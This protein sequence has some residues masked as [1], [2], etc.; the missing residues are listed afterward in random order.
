MQV[1]KRDGRLEAVDISKITKALERF[2]RADMHD[3]DIARVARL[4]M[5]NL[6]DGATTRQIDEWSVKIAAS[7]GAE[8]PRYLTFAAHLFNNVINK[9]VETQGFLDFEKYW[10]HLGA[11]GYIQPQWIDPEFQDKNRMLYA[12]INN[13]LLSYWDEGEGDILDSF[14]GL[15]ALYSSYLLRAKV[16]NKVIETVPHLMMRVALQLVP[17]AAHHAGYY[18]REDYQRVHELF[19]ALMKGE[20]MPGTPTLFNSCL[21]RNQLASC[22]LLPPPDDSIQGI[23]DYMGS[24]AQL[25][26]WSGG[27][28]VPFSSVRGAGSHIFGT[29]GKSQGIIPFLKVLDSTV[30]AVNQ[31]GKRKGACAVYL[32]PW[33]PDIEEFLELRD[34]TGAESRRTHNLN[35]VNWVP[36]LFM[37]AVENDDYWYLIDPT[38]CDKGQLCDVYGQKFE[39]LYMNYVSRERYCKRIK[40]RDLYAKMMKTLAETGNG[41]MTFKDAANEKSVQSDSESFGIIHSSNLCTEI[42]QRTS[43]LDTSVCSIGSINVSVFATDSHTMRKGESYPLFD[44]NRF[45]RAVG[46]AIKAIYEGA[47]HRWEPPTVPTNTIEFM[48]IGLGVMGLADVAFKLGIP[49]TSPMMRRLS[50]EIQIRMY[51]TAF[52]TLQLEYPAHS[53]KRTRLCKEQVLSHD[54]WNVELPEWLSE[55]V[56]STFAA[57]REDMTKGIFPDASLLIAIAPTATISRIAGCY[58]SVEPQLS[59]M[60]K[61]ETL[62]GEFL[63]INK[64]LVRDLKTLGLWTQETRDALVAANGSVQGFEDLPHHYKEVYRTVWEIQQKDLIDMAAERGPYIDQGQSLNLFIE[65]PSIGKLSSMYMYAWKRGLKTTYYLRSRPA[66]EIKKTSIKQVSDE[67]AIACS[68]ENPESCE[69]CQ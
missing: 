10:R 37:R 60:F 24:A 44:F 43:R 8:D 41:W 52:R 56:H 34:N 21:W 25:S 9:E 69:S 17:P 49:F 62:F 1:Q 4:T 28:G 68:L 23:F 51:A 33:H 54:L 7:L 64:Y 66:S 59:N 20:F 67:A 42:L 50:Q 15:V 36:D 39:Q 45:E 31:G 40:A 19:R 47:R 53:L 48:P 32:E 12:Q 63:Q 2:R 27:L 29:S 5:E 46:I 65:S 57:I 3:L 61:R 55:D 35:L 11:Y 22:F 30:G 18:T 38:A 6:F 14:S 58:E 16:T 13:M 26:K